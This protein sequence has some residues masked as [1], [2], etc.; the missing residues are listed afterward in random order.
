MTSHEM[1]ETKACKTYLGYATGVTPLKKIR[2]FK[3]PASPKLTTVLASHKEPI[4]KSKRVKRP[5]KKCTNAPTIGVVIKDN[6]GVFV[7]K[8]KAPT[9][10][11]RGKGIELL[12]DAA[13]LKDDQLKKALMK[14]RQETHKL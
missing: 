6:P 4:K 8:K 1:R 14:S 12:S 7:L 10:A 3:K 9:K 13:L 2:K 5:A 11:D